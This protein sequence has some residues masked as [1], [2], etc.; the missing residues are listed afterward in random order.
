MAEQH[1]TVSTP[2]STRRP[3]WAPRFIDVYSATGNVRLA[4][5]AAGVSREAPYKKAQAN[6]TF[7]AD[8]LRAREDAIDVLEAEARRRALSTSDTLLM[9]LLKADR[10]DKYR[11]KV[12]VRFDLRR[13]AERIASSLG[14]DVEA[15]IAEAERILESS[16]V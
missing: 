1:S 10:P 8:W 2:R 9:F 5:T 3:D 7:A 15:A 12:D 13:E 16:G 4:A 14:I 6:P 11:D